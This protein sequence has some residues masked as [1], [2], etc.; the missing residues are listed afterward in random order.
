MEIVQNNRGKLTS[1]IARRYVYG[2]GVDTPL[3]WYEGA[4][5]TDR[6]WLIPDERGSIIAV[7]GASGDVMTINGNPAINRYDEYGIPASTNV[8]RFQ[9]TGQAWIPE[10]GMYY[11]K[12]RIYAPT[13]GRFMQTDPIGYGDGMNLYNYVGS[14]PVNFTDPSGLRSAEIKTHNL[15]VETGEIVVTGERNKPDPVADASAFANQLNNDRILD[16]LSALGREGRPVQEAGIGKIL[17]LLSKLRNLG[18]SPAPKPTPRVV[19]APKNWKPSVHQPQQPPG[20]IPPGWR[21]RPMP[22]N[23]LYPNGYWRLEKPMGNGG[24][25]GINPSTG[26][27]GPQWE[28]HI[29]FP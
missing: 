25:Q 22:P 15:P 5:T 1:L 17:D 8:G 6:R 9:Y 2:P 21:V 16:Q 3:V 4:G 11:Y 12:A 27:P 18:K 10:L 7:T 24:W 14:D 28:T 29:P 23:S 20:N 26:K 13:L 19:P